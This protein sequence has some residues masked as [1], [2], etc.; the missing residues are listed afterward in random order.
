MRGGGCGK[1]ESKH[2][3]KG[4]PLRDDDDDDDETGLVEFCVSM[5]SFFLSLICDCCLV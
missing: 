4:E 1:C 5:H 2:R 3:A